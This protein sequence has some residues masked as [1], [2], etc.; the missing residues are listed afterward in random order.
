MEEICCVEKSMNG[1]E[2]EA[3]TNFDIN[4]QI[5]ETS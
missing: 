3:T 4:T 5:G 1:C 2:L